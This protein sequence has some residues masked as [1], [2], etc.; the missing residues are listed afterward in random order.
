MAGGGHSQREIWI[1]WGFGW[2]S[3]VPRGRPVSRLGHFSAVLLRVKLCHER[4]FLCQALP[5]RRSG[6]RQDMVDTVLSLEGKCKSIPEEVGM[7]RQAAPLL[8]AF[9]GVLVPSLLG[10]K[11]SI[12]ARWAF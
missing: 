8:L 2:T 6:L 9:H 1:S 11:G 12:C 10:P 3:E 4:A 7:P 5:K